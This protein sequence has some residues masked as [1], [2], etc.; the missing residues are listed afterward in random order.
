MTNKN[1]Q[2]ILTLGPKYSYSY[3]VTYKKY[4]NKYE[5][6]CEN[7][8]ENVFEKVSKNKNLIGIVPIENLINGNVRES[9]L[10]LKKYKVK[11]NKA[12]DFNIKHCL[13]S[14]TKEFKEITSHPQ[15]IAQSSEF[16]KTY[17]KNN[18][19]ISTCNSTSKAMK[20]AKENQNYAGIGSE[21]AAKE[22]GLKILAT[23]IGNIE[24]NITR[25]IEISQ[26]ETI[27]ENSSNIKTSL[28]IEPKIDRSG[29]L[30]E[31]L[32][33]FKIKDINLTKIESIPNGKKIGEYIFYI[34]ID[35][36]LNKTK[37]QEAI[38]FLKTIVNIHLFGSY[39]IEKI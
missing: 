30:F 23:N 28:I 26:T 13:A 21:L 31:I 32:S 25:F 10:A 5:I 34:D 35:A 2:K 20:I 27:P 15:A 17:R 36:S 8:I 39:K 11:I 37:V 12:Y 4:N 29:L 16:L 1:K 19:N 22:I 38:N 3:N 24:N 33:I 14:Q 7:Q 6:I 9:F 18:I